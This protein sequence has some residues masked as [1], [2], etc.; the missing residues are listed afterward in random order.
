MHS[1]VSLG[2]VFRR[3]VFFWLRRNKKLTRECMCGI[4]QRSLQLSLGECCKQCIERKSLEFSHEFLYFIC[5]RVLGVDNVRIKWMKC[6]RVRVQNF[7]H[8][9]GFSIIFTYSWMC[10]MDKFIKIY[11][12]WYVCYASFAKLLSSCMTQNCF[13]S[14]VSNIV[15]WHFV[16][17]FRNKILYPCR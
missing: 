3:W 8:A 7:V 13:V 5:S 11:T 10:R 15:G 6:W 2:G 17:I 12:I 9:Y 1:D 14:Y 4:K 16:D